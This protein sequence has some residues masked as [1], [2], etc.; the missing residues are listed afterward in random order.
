MHRVVFTLDVTVFDLI[1]RMF[2]LALAII[3]VIALII[4]KICEKIRWKKWE[5]ETIDDDITD[6]EE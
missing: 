5:N 1:V 2:I 3:T 4:S 6:I